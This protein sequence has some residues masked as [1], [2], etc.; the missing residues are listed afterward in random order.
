MTQDMLSLGFDHIIRQ[1]QEMA[2][3]GSACRILG[4]TAPILNG[5][6]RPASA[7]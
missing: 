6:Q 7:G 1:L 4:D 2:V 5:R 3:S